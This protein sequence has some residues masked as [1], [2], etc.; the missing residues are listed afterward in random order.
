VVS[1][2]VVR[3]RCDYKVGR[4]FSFD[5]LIGER[6]ACDSTCLSEHLAIIHMI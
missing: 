3:M 5:T 6:S 4:L 2:W 1:R